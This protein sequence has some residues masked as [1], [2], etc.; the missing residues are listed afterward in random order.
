MNKLKNASTADVVEA[1]VCPVIQYRTDAVVNAL[2]KDLNSV[3]VEKR[4]SLL[5]E[6][7]KKDT[8]LFKSD[9]VV[10]ILS[11]VKFGADLR[12]ATKLINPYILQFTAAQFIKTIK[13][14]TKDDQIIP[15]EEL[16]DT[17]GDVSDKVKDEIVKGLGCGAAKIKEALKEIKARSCVS[18]KMGKNVVFLIDLS[19]S[20]NY[21]F[22]LNGVKNTRLK[23][24][25]PVI[26]SALKS[27]GEENYFKIVS[28]ANSS[29][30]WKEDFL[31]ATAENK[32][33][34]IEWVTKI[35]AMG[36]TNTFAGIQNSFN[37]NRSDFSIQL[38]TD[39]IPSVG[40]KR[41]DNI[42][43]WIKN[44]NADRVK[45]GDHAVKIYANIL[46]LGGTEPAAEKK[47]TVVFYDQ[48]ALLTSGT[49]KNFS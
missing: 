33:A 30:V 36:G 5:V 18:G 9:D 39:G 43:S 21:F 45:K 26:I 38:Y 48:L 28:F 29:R 46:N 25:K 19:G 7:L 17:L 44:T 6:E 24:L 12:E 10:R 40:E 14:Q 34:A 15:L 37:A 2:I 20:M 32:A 1:E 3:A 27:F 42:I 16:K 47:S 22:I 13:A 11:D 41:L 35:N 23:F 49:F 31:P 4:K 8:L